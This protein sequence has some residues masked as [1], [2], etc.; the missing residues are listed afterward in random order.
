[1]NADLEE[2]KIKEL[3]L[4]MRGRDERHAPEFEDLVSRRRVVSVQVHWMR[5]AAAVLVLALIALPAGI[6]LRRA[7]TPGSRVSTPAEEITLLPAPAPAL[8]PGVTGQKPPGSLPPQVTT[9]VHAD[10]GPARRPRHNVYRRP[11]QNSHLVSQWR[12]PTEF[13]LN[14]TGDS[15]LRLTPRLDDSVVRLRLNLGDRSN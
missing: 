10:G 14:V 4:E 9:L 11:T 3:F 15:L 8:Y 6:L 1:M 5:L 7:L 12:S 13:L 2:K